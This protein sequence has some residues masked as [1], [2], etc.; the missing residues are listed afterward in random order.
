MRDYDDALSRQ[1]AT[2]DKTEPMATNGVLEDAAT[3]TD[4]GTI[5]A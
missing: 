2:H 5:I 4:P 3:S 1:I